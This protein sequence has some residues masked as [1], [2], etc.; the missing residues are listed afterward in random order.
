[1]DAERDYRPQAP[2]SGGRH[3]RGDCRCGDKPVGVGDRRRSDRCS[4]KIA[5][6]GEVGFEE[7][8]HE[9]GDRTATADAAAAAVAAA[10]AAFVGG[11]AAGGSCGDRRGGG[12]GGGGGGGA[13][14]KRW[15]LR[16]SQDG[17]E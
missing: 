10:A 9:E 14:Y 4:E 2:I 13:G 11:A 8:E 3:R 7:E 12:G 6:A 17:K 5:P 1:M 15:G 16:G